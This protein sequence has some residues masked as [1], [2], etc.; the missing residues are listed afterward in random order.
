MKELLMQGGAYIGAKKSSRAWQRMLFTLD[1]VKMAL[2]IIMYIFAFFNGWLCLTFVMCADLIVGKLLYTEIRAT[3]QEYSDDRI[4]VLTQRHGDK[5]EEV[6]EVKELRELADPVAFA[7]AEC[8]FNLLITAAAAVLSS[9]SLPGAALAFTVAYIAPDTFVR[10]IGQYVRW[11][12]RQ[13]KLY[14]EQTG[15]D[16]EWLEFGE[17]MLK[18]KVPRQTLAGFFETYQRFVESKKPKETAQ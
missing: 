12:R 7:G 3:L 5:V 11:Y 4:A 18:E 2:S 15:N 13:E 9:V 1:E 8:S 10:S 14:L 17:W 6:A 16:A